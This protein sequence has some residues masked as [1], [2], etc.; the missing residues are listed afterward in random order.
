[1]SIYVN[2][3]NV[4]Q[5]APSASNRIRYYII[6]SLFVGKYI[7]GER[8]ILTLSSFLVSNSS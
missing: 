1:M 7:I 3:F 5:C 8:T 2:G 4:H 6:A